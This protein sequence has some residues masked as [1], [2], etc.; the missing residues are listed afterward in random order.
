M[1]MR[2]LVIQAFDESTRAKRAFLEQNLDTLLN[3]IDVVA[4]ALS[5]G[6]KALLFGNG[7]SAADAQHIAAEFVNRFRI[8][9]PPLAALALTT[10]TSAI[11]S[12][13]NDYEYRQV[14]A[15]QVRALG[16]PGDVAIAI[17][18]SG[19]AASVL[20]AVTVCKELGI[21]T[22]GLTG[23]DG[24]KLAGEVD[25]LLSVSATKSTA[26]IQE[27]HI[28]VG[29]VICEM[30]DQK[31]F[32]ALS[33][34]PNAPFT[35]PPSPRAD[36]RSRGAR[37]SSR[38]LDVLI[39]G[40]GAAGLWC[41]D[42]FR[43][44]GYHAL[45]LESKALGSG[46]TSQAQGIIHG[47][48][49][50]ALRGVRD[51]AAV[52]ATSQMPDRWRRC[53]SGTA[54]PKLAGTRVLSERCYLWLP[55]GSLIA[56]IQSWGFIPLL[57]QTG[58]LASRP[59]KVPLS[60]CPPVLRQSAAAVFALDE[61]VIATGSFLDA[62]FQQN[63]SF[64]FSYDAAAARFAAREVEISGVRLRPR[65]LVLAAGVGNARLLEQL[66]VPVDLMQRRP[67]GMVLLRG[68][69]DPLYGHCVVG[70]KTQLTITTPVAGVWQVGGEIAER[71]AQHEDGERARAEALRDIRRWLPELDVD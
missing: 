47:G 28:L 14:F 62:L 40:G 44:A 64:I 67:L 11:T 2:D 24:G 25:Y 52:R 30:V 19:N 71:L 42:C 59:E 50:Y 39:F 35:A 34:P 9:R 10:D 69:L 60:A 57:G 51:F 55:R 36:T 12:I 54:E 21:T 17:S 22:I 38:T 31:L 65:A 49:K 70:G 32:P 5:R 41:L 48:G 13:A 53:L 18:T 15:K 20:A 45:L 29:H 61:Q 1:T 46:Q 7:G 58:L 68:R 26:R 23:G 27:T 16:K 6:Y 56:T 66:G 8:E 63:E 3:V 43:R 4:Q 37:A 33:P